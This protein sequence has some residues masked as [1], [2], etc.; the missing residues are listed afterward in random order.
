MV[1]PTSHLDT[2]RLRRAFDEAVVRYYDK[3][4]TP[5]RPD[6]PR[7]TIDGEHLTIR[8]VCGLVIEFTD[9]LRS[10][11]LQQLMDCMHIEHRELRQELGRD[12]LYGIGAKCLLKLMDDREGA[13]KQL[14]E[15]RKDNSGAA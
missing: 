7:V 5:G 4:W 11:V 14:K 15:R 1:E 8:Q 12:A 10:D 13:Y 6:F 2:S 9:E 3:Q